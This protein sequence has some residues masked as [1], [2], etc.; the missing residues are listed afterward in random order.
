M[1]ALHSSTSTLR[2]KSNVEENRIHFIY[3][4]L[5]IAITSSKFYIPR[6]PKLYI[7][8][9]LKSKITNEGLSFQILRVKITK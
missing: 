8:M 1:R 5:K 4:Q 6:G 7:T 2:K 9:I 3:P